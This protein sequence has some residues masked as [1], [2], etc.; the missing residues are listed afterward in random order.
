MKTVYVVLRCA[1]NLEYFP[2]L[3][4]KYLDNPPSTAICA[5]KRVPI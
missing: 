4:G 1:Y 2:F 5:A 3:I